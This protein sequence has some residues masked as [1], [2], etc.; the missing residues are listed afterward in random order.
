MDLDRH[1]AGFICRSLRRRIVCLDLAE[2]GG[3]PVRFYSRKGWRLKDEDVPAVLRGED[4]LAKL[5]QDD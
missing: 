2:G 1:D 4:P 5:E 3:K